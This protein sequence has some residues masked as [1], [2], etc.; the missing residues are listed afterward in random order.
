[1]AELNTLI[2]K[3]A[4]IKSKLTIFNSF[5]TKIDS[6]LKTNAPVNSSE[7]ISLECRTE[8]A[9]K[10]LDCFDE[11]QIDIEALVENLDEQHTERENFE[12]SFYDCISKAKQILIDQTGSTRS[13]KSDEDDNSIRSH[14]SSGTQVHGIKLPTIKL[15]NFCGTYEGWLEYRDTFESLIHN[16]TLINDVQKFH[17]LKASL[18]GEAADVIKS[19]EFSTK[20]YIV[21]WE[22]LCHRY[23][24][25]R[26]LVHNHMKALFNIQRLD[27]ESSVHI[28]KLID[29]VNKHLRALQTLKQP[30][31][32]WDTLIIYLIST[33]LDNITAREWEQYK[34]EDLPTLENLK[35]FLKSRADLLETL[36]QSKSNQT[37]INKKGYKQQNTNTFFIKKPVCSFCKNE[38]FIQ[39]CEDFLKL[40]INARLNEVKKRKMCINCLRPNHAVNECR[41]RTCQKCEA[42]HN[43]LL[44]IENKNTQ[45][46]DTVNTPVALSSQIKTAQILLST[47]LIQIRDNNG[48]YHTVRALLDAGSQS[49]FI[50]TNLSDKLQLNREK[51]DI[52]VGGLNQ[53]KSLIKYKCAV[54]IKAQHTNYSKNLSCLTVPEIT[55][56]LPNFQ[57]NRN[58][59]TIPPHIKL[60]DPGFHKSDKVEVLLGA[61]IFWELTCVGQIK[62]TQ[63]PILQKTKFGWIVSG[64][65][66][67]S[68]T[69]TTFCNLNQINLEEQLQKFWQIEQEYSNKKPLSDE[70]NAC[71]QHFIRNTYRD[72]SGR[73]VVSLPL[74]QDRNVLGDSKTCAMKRFQSLERKLENNSSLRDKYISFMDE[75]VNL[76]HMTKVQDDSQTNVCYYMPHHGVLKEDRTTTKLRVVFDASAVTTSGYSLNNIQMVGPTIQ[77]DLFS[78][79][80]RFRTHQIVISADIEK[81]YRQVLTKPEDR[82]LQRILW[83]K[84]CQDPIETYELNTV[85]YGT[86]AASFLA[87]RCLHQLGLDC[88]TNSAEISYRILNDFYVDDLLSGCNTVGEAINI[89]Q[90]ISQVLEEGGFKLRK[91]VSN[92]L[93]VILAIAERDNQSNS[94]ILGEH[95]NTKTLGLI[96]VNTS[97]KLM[98]TISK[99]RSTNITKRFILSEISQIFDPFGLLSPCTITAKIIIQKLWLEKVTWDES[100]PT[101]I[102][103]KWVKF[104]NDLMCLNELELDRRVI[105][106]DCVNV[107]IHAFSDS[108]EHAYGSCVYVRAQSRCGK[109]FVNLLCSKAKVA[110]VKSMTIPR[111]E[112]CGALISAKLVD[113]VKDSLN[114]KIDSVTYWTDSTI[115]MGWIHTS[116]HLLQIFVGN[117]VSQIQT[118]TDS[119][120][121]RHVPT[122]ENPADFLSRG[123]SPLAM[124]DLSTW[125]H[126]PDWLTK[127]ASEWPTLHN[128]PNDNLPDMRK[129]IQTFSVTVQQDTFPFEKYSNFIKLKRIIAYC[130]RFKHNCLKPKDERNYGPIDENELK[131]SLNCLVKMAQ[132]ECFIDEF[133]VLSAGKSVDRKSRLLSLNPFIENGI[134]RVGGRLERSD[135][136]YNKKHPAVLLSKHHLT[137]L[138]FQWEHQRLLHAGPQLLLASVREQFWPILGKNLAKKTVRNCIRC[139]K[140]KPKVSNAIMGHL[141]EARVRPSPPFFNSGIDYAGPFSIKD[142]KGRGC[143]V[144]KCYICLFIC[145]ST[146]ALHLEVVSN[147]TTEAFLACFRRFVSR[148]GRPHQVFSD[149]GSNLVGARNELRNLGQ[150]L[151]SNFSEL[152]EGMNFDGMTWKFIPAYSPHFGGLWEAGVKSAKYHLLRVTNGTIL[153]FEELLT[154]VVQVESV[155]NSRPMSALSSDPN[156]LS[157]LTP[158]HFLIGRPLT[159]IVDEDLADIRMSRLSRFQHIQQMLQHFWARWSKVFITELQQRVKNKIHCPPL[160]KGSLVLIK[161]DN[162]PPLKWKLGRIVEIHPGSDGVARVASIYT[163]NGITKRAYTKI[164]PL[165]FVKEA[166]D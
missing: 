2:R 71:E 106:T 26:L 77:Q 32:T 154:L 101:Y 148:R 78:I 166:I 35:Q 67:T 13:V 128:I 144:T 125:W 135:F 9:Q 93:E 55:G 147:L 11:V 45:Q 138:I 51:I 60:A 124:Q 10:L 109:V 130:L 73:F 134:I 165:P 155:L 34:T 141:P 41:S 81:M 64:P 116:P 86:A 1:M 38:H 50:T 28:R 123:V 112:L 95:E 97:D 133:K 16:N 115:V 69:Q 46:T 21:A 118:L 12:T 39:N 158:G 140:A 54:Q 120:F 19:L 49:N 79:L 99:G 159:A 5:V 84:H 113:K 122:A 87:I 146:R 107:Q 162:Q 53:T 102:H 75:Y 65:I 157:P 70:E 131:N 83:R 163:T 150:F 31:E 47:A 63:G 121:W 88:K 90:S 149:N 136:D 108:S 36:E 52:N 117:R 3:R 23:N 129:N 66:R 152:S 82:Q 103:T 160:E 59:L 104:R 42:K 7:I 57:I 98:F 22:L 14:S 145:F 56:R 161:E 80:L 72:S 48:K 127:D 137:N 85:T 114:I 27:R 62:L 92:N 33:K 151:Q 24:N 126:G 105:C 156:D 74:K 30:T 143:K 4:S 94:V 91:W 164:C 18:T 29:T 58:L 111:L 43:T 89:A 76:G 20:N 100:L 119:D 61:E 96:W 37:F 110:P 15:P 139:F 8:Q 40:N 44:H 6:Q 17:Y 25:T 153:T 68:Q 132:R 142:R